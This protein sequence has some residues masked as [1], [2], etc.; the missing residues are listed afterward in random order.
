LMEKLEISD[1]KEL[2]ERV[3]GAEQVEK[4]LRTA[5]RELN[6][7]RSEPQALE[8]ERELEQLRRRVE[9]CEAATTGGHTSVSAETIIR[10]LAQLDK[11]ISPMQAKRGLP[12]SR[13]PNPP[14]SP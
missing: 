12:A 2:L 11:E 3:E 6:Q 14:T 4:Q 13:P 1:P 9:P 5:E 7:V 10:R 8:A